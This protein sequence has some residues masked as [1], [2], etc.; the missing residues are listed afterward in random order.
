MVN[1]AQALSEGRD[2]R[3]VGNINS[4]GVNTRA[5]VRICQSGFV[6]A[7]NDN[8]SA[9]RSSRNRD[10]TG[11]AT[12]LPHHDNG[13]SLQRLTHSLK[14][15][16]LLRRVSRLFVLLSNSSTNRMTLKRP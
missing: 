4:L 11:D 13:F 6:A 16:V 15:P 10:S 7:S 12:P 14:S 1:R 8:S 2:R 5:P 3:I 9:P